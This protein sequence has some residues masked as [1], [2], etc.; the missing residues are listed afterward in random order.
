[1][2]DLQVSF[3]GGPHA[4]PAARRALGALRAPLGPD[5]F[6]DVSLLVSELVTNSVRHGE[7]GP[8]GQIELN[9]DVG[10]DR[11][12]VEVDDRGLGFDARTAPRMDSDRG[13]GFGLYLVDHLADRWQT[14]RHDG[15]T[16]VWFEL[17]R[18]RR[19]AGPGLG[20]GMP[21]LA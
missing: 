4:A 12:R 11:V 3:R 20:L 1:M 10:D 9:V 2:A 15:A 19:T 16:R 7:V 6:D 17:S 13:G 14:E 18:S 21:V 8:D 5:L